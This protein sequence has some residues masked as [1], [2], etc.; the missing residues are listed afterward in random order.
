M[1]RRSKL[2]LIGLIFLG[3]MTLCVVLLGFKQAAQFVILFIA[4]LAPLIFGLPLIVRHFGYTGWKPFLLVVLFVGF[5]FSEFSF[6]GI[7]M[8]ESGISWGEDIKI[9]LFVGIFV[10]IF[11]VFVTSLYSF[12]FRSIRWFSKMSRRWMETKKEL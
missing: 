3:L 8:S 9:S 6:I 10:S 1:T 2:L 11:G 12:T 7:A 5:C 4:M